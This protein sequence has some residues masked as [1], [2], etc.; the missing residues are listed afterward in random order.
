MISS[1]L[2]EHPLTERYRY[3]STVPVN[4]A[5]IGAGEGSAAALDGTLQNAQTP[6]AAKLEHY[7]PPIACSVFWPIAF[8]K[9]YVEERPEL[10]NFFALEW[11][12][13]GLE[14]SST[15]PRSRR[16][17][18][19]ITFTNRD[20][21]VTR[22]DWLD[23]GLKKNLHFAF[24]SLN[25]DLNYELAASVAEAR[26]DAA[27]HVARRPGAPTFRDERIGIY[28]P[29]ATSRWETLI[30]EMAR[31]IDRVWMAINSASDP[32]R[33]DE[34]VSKPVNRY[35][36][37]SSRNLACALTDIL[38]SFSL[39]GSLFDES[40]RATAANVLARRL[41]DD[42]YA[43]GRLAL[44]MHYRWIARMIC[45]GWRPYSD[46]SQIFKLGVKCVTYKQHAGIAAARMESPLLEETGLNYF[47]HE[48]SESDLN[49]LDELDWIN[50]Q[51]LRHN[52]RVG[53]DSPPRIFKRNGY[54]IALNIPFILTGTGLKTGDE[55]HF[56]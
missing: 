5:I 52:L 38:S 20:D 34:D 22:R 25:D 19:T 21:L 3:Q 32:D 18:G 12:Y 37:K 2:F 56:S 27:V 35:F 48:A 51:I 1:Y 15:P 49:Q 7:A 43:R 46:V 47:L 39:E 26:P 13:D 16:S 28:D 30:D 24:V 41:I 44:S 36:Y 10:A 40:T 29:N 42:P 45:D 31:R 55:L 11:R 50:V 53:N 6:S 4:V 54:A 33:F 14:M 8:A 9:Q 23:E 17:L